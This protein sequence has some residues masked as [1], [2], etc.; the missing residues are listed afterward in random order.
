MSSFHIHAIKAFDDNYIWAI[1]TDQHA[2]IIDPGSAD[3]LIS[4]L[5]VHQLTP[6]AILITHHHH[7]HIGGVDKLMSLYKGCTLYAHSHHG[8]GDAVI[9][10]EGSQ[11]H[12]MGLDFTVQMSAGHTDSHL[13]YL[14]QMDGVM[15]V[16]CGD[17]L[18]SGGCGRVFTGTI[19][20]LYASF[21]RYLSLP[22]ETLFYPAHEYTLSNLKFAQTVCADS[23]KKTIETAILETQARLENAKISLPTQLGYEKQ[24]N[25]F[26]H[27]FEP[28]LRQAM[29]DKLGCA[30]DGLSVFTAL[31]IAK[32]N[33]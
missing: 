4:Y 2:I 22:D 14:V 18:F 15:R 17:T 1:R 23:A 24:I 26:M 27:S 5:N 10:D 6:V 29:A 11:L 33:A 12:I 21:E 32:N 31:R 25:V 19:E 3:E 16:F 7:D 30:D 20:Q 13:S 9:V 8:L 28:S